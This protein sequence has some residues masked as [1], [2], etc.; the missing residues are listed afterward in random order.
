[1]AL[2]GAERNKN[3]WGEAPI[4]LRL[5]RAVKDFFHQVSARSRRTMRIEDFR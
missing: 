3:P 1:M 4:V 5:R 2:A